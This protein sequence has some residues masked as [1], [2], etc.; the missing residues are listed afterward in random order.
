MVHVDANAQASLMW[1]QAVGEILFLLQQ[2]SLYCLVKMAAK[3]GRLLML[4]NARTAML[5][6][7]V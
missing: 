1:A 7:F 3:V 4:M 2:I 6:G 5:D